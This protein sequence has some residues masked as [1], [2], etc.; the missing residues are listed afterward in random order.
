M[1]ADA[2][3]QVIVYNRRAEVLPLGGG[4]ELSPATPEAKRR[5]ADCLER[6]RAEGGTDYVPALKRALAFEPE[7]IFF[8]TD[9]DELRLEQIQA[10]TQINRG[11]AVIH[12]IELG[13]DRPARGDSRLE[14]LAR[15]NQGSYRLVPL[16]R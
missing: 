15:A 3:F 10:I 1:P 16:E 11:R 14:V 6:F 12:A 13:G 9:G 2:R 7:V 8:L 4:P 5:A